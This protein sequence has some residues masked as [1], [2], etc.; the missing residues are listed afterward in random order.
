M[1]MTK[2]DML[3]EMIDA[4]NIRDKEKAMKYGLKRKVESIARAFDFYQAE[5]VSANFCVHVLTG[6][7]N[8]NI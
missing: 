2:K 5:E 3:K 8:A 4:S 1:V 6:L 7:S